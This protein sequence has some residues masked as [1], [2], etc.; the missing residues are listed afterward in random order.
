[1]R[2]IS[3][4]EL[5]I[6]YGGVD[7]GELVAGAVGSF[8]GGTI[9]SEFGPVGTRAGQA[10]GGFLGKELYGSIREGYTTAPGVTTGVGSYNPNYN[11][12]LIGS[13]FGPSSSSAGFGS[14]ASASAGSGS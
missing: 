12:G 10:V 6:V 5:E 1:M 7:H 4:K 11:P 8:I 9:G 13:G 14:S 2:A 3:A